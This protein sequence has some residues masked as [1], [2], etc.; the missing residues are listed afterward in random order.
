MKKFRIGFIVIAVIVIIVTITLLDYNNLSW[1]NNRSN[2]GS[3]ILMIVIIIGML[4][5]NWHE[6]KTKS[7]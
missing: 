7:K 5:S 3:I 4:Y 6:G 2:Y 1:S